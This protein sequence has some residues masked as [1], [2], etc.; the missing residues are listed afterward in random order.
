MDIVK[1]FLKTSIEL[2]AHY[3]K[4]WSKIF[5]ND[6]YVFI[7]NAIE[8]Y[9]NIQNNKKRD[10][11]SRVINKRLYTG[12][13]TVVSPNTLNS[14]NNKNRMSSD[15]LCNLTIQI[16][17]ILDY[18]FEICPRLPMD[19]TVFR[20]FKLHND[21][22]LLSLQQGDFYRD[23]GIGGSTINPYYMF[24]RGSALVDSESGENKKP[25]KEVYLTTILSKGARC[26]YTNI[27]WH[28][29]STNYQ[30]EFE[31]VLPR[32]CVYFIKSKQEFMG[33]VFITFELVQ[34]IPPK[35]RPIESTE[36]FL[37]V[38]KLDK[39]EF[40]YWKPSKEKRDE[41]N[42]IMKIYKEEYELW[43]KLPQ[44]QKYA[45]YNSE[46]VSIRP[47]KIWFYTLY[48]DDKNFM[49]LLKNKM[50]IKLILHENYQIYT[51]DKYL[52][53]PKKLS[54]EY[55]EKYFTKNGNNVRNKFFEID[56]KIPLLY[57]IEVD[58]CKEIK[59]R[60]NN[61]YM[62]YVTNEISVI[63]KSIEYK[64]VVDEYKYGVVKA[65]MA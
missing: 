34:Q 23:L 3:H 39:N 36:E 47:K 26:Y 53:L 21:D 52:Y 16:I 37:P 2:E 5:H 38:R 10:V 62:W 27:P 14:F 65:E 24:S 1:K 12:K 18:V 55:C 7:K 48:N 50:N 57:L 30:N 33:K 49:D 41:N 64:E 63:V 58:K 40:T 51:N 22:L 45:T 35:E 11:Y 60:K 46:L 6:A 29:N 4:F 61:S 32:D 31:I 25:E 13:C 44:D 19:T 15:E 28:Y 42:W 8:F 9:K 56:R 43:N 59:V 20:Y 17:N 54:D